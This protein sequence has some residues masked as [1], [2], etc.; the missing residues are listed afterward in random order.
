MLLLEDSGKKKV[1][2]LVTR[3]GNDCPARKYIEV[4][5]G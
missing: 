4:S 1:L 3:E 5:C 2:A